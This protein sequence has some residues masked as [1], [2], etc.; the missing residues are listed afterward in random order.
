[1]GPQLIHS[2]EDGCLLEFEWPSAAVCIQAAIEGNNCQIKNPAFGFLDL[3]P[4]QKSTYYSVLTEKY[5]FYLNVC[6]SI[7]G[8]PCQQG[9]EN[10]AACQMDNQNRQVL[11]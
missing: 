6:N 2:S 10:I 7:K 8:A 3:M 9:N 11:F 1:M 5:S 4:L